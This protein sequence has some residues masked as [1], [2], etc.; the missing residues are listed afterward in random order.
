MI[1]NQFSGIDRVAEHIFLRCR[2][3]WLSHLQ[4]L[5]EVRRIRMESA[6]WKVR[7]RTVCWVTWIAYR[8]HRCHIVWVLRF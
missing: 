2:L 7:G 5:V 4:M 6:R 3:S 8:L 1:I